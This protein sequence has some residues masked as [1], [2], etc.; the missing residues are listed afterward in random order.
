MF[1]FNKEEKMDENIVWLLATEKNDDRYFVF[2]VD[3]NKKQITWTKSA[4]E[5]IMFH[6]ENGAQSFFAK[7]IEKTRPNIFLL[8][9]SDP[10]LP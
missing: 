9:I 7:F 10:D 8:C 2:E 6:N 5:G 1:Y 3:T 4:R